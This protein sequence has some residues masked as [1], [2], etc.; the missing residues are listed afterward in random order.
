MNANVKVIAKT[1]EAASTTN[2][3][4]RELYIRSIAQTQTPAV[5]AVTAAIIIVMVSRGMISL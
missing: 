4:L 1:I 2:E 3:D 5:A